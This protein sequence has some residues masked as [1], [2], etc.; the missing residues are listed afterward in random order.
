MKR[1][2][3]NIALV[4][5][6]A[7]L[8]VGC[9]KNIQ[10]NVPPS[11]P[12]VVVEG[13]IEQGRPPLIMLS[14]SQGF[15]DPTSVS[16]LA[17]SFISDAT[18]VMNGDTLTRICSSEIPDSLLLQISNIS[19][20]SAQTLAAIDLCLYTTLDTA[21][22]G[23]VGTTY[24]LKVFA[25]GKELNSITS[26]PHPIP[27]DS[28]WFTLYG[29][30]TAYGVINA[31]LSDPDTTGNYYRWQAQRINHNEDGEILDFYPI[32]PFGSVFD[33][34]FING[35]SFH[36]FYGRGT[37]PGGS[38]PSIYDKDG[39]FRKGDTVVVKFS[40][41][42]HSAYEFYQTFESQL[43]STGNPFATPANVVSNI[44]GGLGIWAG[45]GASYD[46]LICHP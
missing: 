19:G 17:N 37:N 9:E 46:T 27:L 6:F 5:G 43:G 10:I 30:D 24:S 7:L 1:T 25:D 29:S 16:S 4:F 3:Q 31:R 33:D 36:F 44:D 22:F 42:P 20:I 14:R 32:A 38:N 11:T 28:L 41:I 15:F 23:H 26:I 12:E 13:T 39:L 35:T 2:G 45:Y 8:I 40:C 34:Q 18:V 21:Q